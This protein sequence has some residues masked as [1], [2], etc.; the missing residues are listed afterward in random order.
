MEST[1]AEDYENNPIL[2]EEVDPNNELKSF[3][4]NHVGNKVQPDDNN[5]TV[6]MIVETMAEEL[7]EFVLVLAEENWIRGY[8]Q[9]L[10][11]VDTGRKI[12]EE[13]EI[14]VVKKKSCKL[15]EE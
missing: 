8:E 14:A 9:A 10:N 11:D 7:P 4:I 1:K 5:V 3:L 2:A 6:E 12:V 15:C 13:N